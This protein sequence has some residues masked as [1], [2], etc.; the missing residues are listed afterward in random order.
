VLENLVQRYP[1]IPAYQQLLALCYRDRSS[2]PFLRDNEQEQDNRSKAIA[3]FE[4]LRDDFPGNP[5][6]RHDL[7]ETYAAMDFREMMFSNNRD[8]AEKQ[9][10]KAVDIS[11]E[12]AKD[13]PDV[14]EYA[15]SD[16]SIRNRLASVLY[17]QADLSDSTR[18]EALL[19]EAEHNFRAAHDAA[20]SIV[21]RF[22]DAAPHK[23]SVARIEQSLAEVLRDRNKLEEARLLIES[24]IAELNQLAASDPRMWFIHYPLSDAYRTLAGLLNEMGE[25]DS[26]IEATLKAE[27]H[28]Q[29]AR[30][31]QRGNRGGRPADSQSGESRPGSSRSENSKP[32]VTGTRETSK[33]NLP[34]P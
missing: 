4:K 7:A 1:S 13:Y 3:I 19:D 24:S 27:Q 26:A 29:Q 31:R 33:E 22:P 15:I 2:G 5:Q 18:R 28:R 12:L 9:L 23:I 32:P 14:P 34:V 21:T 6:Y 25:D 30:G 11:S 17:R 20:A 8:V 10:R 16:M